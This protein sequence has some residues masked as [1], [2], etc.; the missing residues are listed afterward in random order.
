[1]RTVILFFLFITPQLFLAQ[2]ILILKSG[3]EIQAKVNEVGTKEIKYKKFSN[4]TGP[5][6]TI[7]KSEVFM[8]KYQ[9]GS[10]D[11]FGDLESKESN[12]S[13][14]KP[15]SRYKELGVKN[16]FFNLRYYH[17][18]LKV[19]KSQFLT[20]LRTDTEA[21]GHYSD[22]VNRH[23]IAR[24]FSGGSLIGALLAVN[25]SINNNTEAV[26]ATAIAGLI[27]GGI[28]RFYSNRATSSLELA[29]LTFNN[30]LNL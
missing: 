13:A 22:Y 24:V 2:D 10:K 8:I 6:Y 19:G 3:D 14:G 15:N 5:V 29:V 21:Y 25:A 17:G 11:V 23:W 12:A 26:Y 18:G 4:L 9:N 30:N 20:I 28:G 7:L 1:M 27:S 16:G